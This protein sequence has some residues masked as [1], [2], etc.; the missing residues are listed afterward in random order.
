[1]EYIITCISHRRPENI[2]Q[3]YETTGTEDIVFV[4]NDEI[5]KNLYIKN[6]AKNIILGGSL[7]GNRNAALDYCFNKN[8]ICVQI[9]DD[10]INVS[11]ND[12]TGKRTNLTIWLC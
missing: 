5:D 11:L 1:M 4:V 7:V 9:D 12:F 8:K 2:K 10:L 6:G 3:I